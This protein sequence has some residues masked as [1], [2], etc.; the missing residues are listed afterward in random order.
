MSISLSELYY[1]GKNVYWVTSTAGKMIPSSV[2]VAYHVYCGVGSVCNN[3]AYVVNKVGE[4]YYRKSKK[5]DPE[6]IIVEEADDFI[7][8]SH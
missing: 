7:V 5:T 3:T 8:L 6:I 4:L 1:I 2:W